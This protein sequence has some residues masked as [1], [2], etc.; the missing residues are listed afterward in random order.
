M[1]R[2]VRIKPIGFQHTLKIFSL[3]LAAR[4]NLTIS[5]YYETKKKELKLKREIEQE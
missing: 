3:I 4:D 5:V 1:N 2:S